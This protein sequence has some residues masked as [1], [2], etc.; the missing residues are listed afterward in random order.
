MKNFFL[1]LLL[2]GIITPGI[3][4]VT[5]QGTIKRGSTPNTV[6]IYLKP[7]ASFSQKD[8]SLTF[9]LAV[10]ASVAPAPTMG[11]A[12]VTPNTTGPVSNI[13][14]LQPN[15]LVVNYGATSREVMVTTQTINGASYYIYTFI[16]AG[17]ATNNHDWVAGQEQLIFSVQFNGCTANC[18]QLNNILLVN[19]PAGG[20][21]GNSYWYVQVNTL[22]DITNYPAPFYQNPQSS[23]PVNGG[24]PDG[25]AL[26][27]IGLAPLV[28]PTLSINDVTQAEG[29]AGTSVFNFTV[30]LSSPAPAGGVSFNISTADGTATA[31]SD[32]VA[33]SATGQ[34]PAGAT[35]YTFAVTVNGDNTVEP[36]E[37]FFVNLSSPTGATI[38]DG[39]GVGTINNDDVAPLPNL[40]INDVTQA[41]GNA[42]TSVFTFT[43]SLSAPAPAGG[44]SFT[45]ATA[46]GTATAGSDYVARSATGQIP[47]GASTYTFDVT[48]N[49]DNTVEPNETFFVNVTGATGA[50]I[51]DGQGVGT[52]NNDDVAPLPTLSIND[53]TQAEGNAGTSVF[54]FT[55]SLS[56]PA[57][58]GGVSFTIATADGTATAGSD[59]VARSATGQIPAGASTYTF[60]VTVNGDNTVEP[61]ETFFVNVTGATGATITDGQ[62]VGTINN[63]D[64]APLPTLS[65]NDVTQAEGNAGTSV[66]TFTVSLSAPAPA[67][68][69]S[70]TIATADG[71]ATAGSDYVARSATGQIPAG[72]STYTFDVTVNGDNTVEPNETFF[73]NVTGATGATITDGQGVGTINNDDV[74]PLPNLSINDVTQAEGNAGTSVFTFTVSLSAPAPAGGVSFTIA[75]ADG[76]ATAGS[77]YVARSATGQIPAG[78][79][80]YTFDVTV[81]GDNTVEP[82]ETFF[83]N[84]TG[85]TGATITD[86]Q[87]VGTINNDDVAPLPN[88]SINDV[89]QAEG[90]A[91]TSAFTFTVSLSAP[92][93]AG[94]VSFTIATAD[95][96]ATAGSDYVAR[97][98]TGQIPAGA[99]TYTFDVTVN[100]DNTVEADETFLVTLSSVTGANVTR[101]QGLG[102]ISNDDAT[103]L[104]SLTINDVTQAEGNAGTSVFTFTVS[105][106]APAPAGG[107]SFTIA[108]A[109]GTAT[110]GSDYVARS[111]TNQTIPAGASTYTFD[112]TVNG[113]NTV[114]ADE[115]FL[116]TLSSVTGANVTRAQ[117][118]G[119]ISNDDAT[120]LPSLTINDVTQ[121]EGNAGTSVFTFTVSLSAPAPAGG[122]SFNIGTADGTATAGS[123][124]VAR[125]LTNQ[126]IPA[127]ASTYT[128]DVTVNGDNTVE[129]N[130]TFFV[131]VTGVTGAVI[132]DGQGVGTISNDDVAPLP[133]LSINDV[134]QAEGNAGTSVF[135]FTVSLSAPAPAGGVS[136]NI[137]TADGTATAG[138]DYVARSLTNQT[139]P[140]GASTYTFDVTVNGDN[141]VEPNETFFVNVTGVTGAVIADGQ[142]V[143]TISND[144]ATPLPSLTIND[145]TQAE[146]NAGTSVFTF[147]VSLS[148]PAPAGGVSFN[149]ATADGTATAG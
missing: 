128:F 125:S 104:P 138:S 81:N 70:F 92:A 41:E 69:V 131:N 23:T 79:S 88:L 32:Y 49:G 59:Y 25:A 105:L 142:G 68:G 35:T 53:V 47:A 120:P 148:A 48:V 51:T 4:Q 30:T 110:A 109:D 97:S 17:T 122:V 39:Q 11:S 117:G 114:E 45:I 58:A 84:V 19:L 100:G 7:S 9:V 140:A 12:G 99:S 65:I 115:T 80:T 124:Y 26:S 44:V 33:R 108:T 8:E 15:F 145:V 66:F 91:G 141:T 64:V 143:G 95:G 34:I 55:V 137:A 28:V 78:A 132:A 22:G 130:E 133:N 94:G 135:T 76:T 14:G 147:T 1:L 63:D 134:T 103:P 77:D 83:V 16:F 37:T 42:G 73:V 86:G 6:D 119:T 121:A 24:S 57:P 139:I 75:T 10:P 96:T 2:L 21:Q 40:S 93:P 144:D 29:N 118:L 102:T 36:N 101:A 82:N 5:M 3:S 52:I 50:T 54:T 71:T 149:I 61:N 107:V 46:D 127:G 74:A 60:D 111:L 113:D 62:G 112:V 43:V 98:A 146:G 56:A 20:V 126:T 67:G 106:S 116:V 87:G 90:N 38:A 136:F 89:T 85:A 13:S 31:G 18:D 27:Y 72:A 123:D 129:P